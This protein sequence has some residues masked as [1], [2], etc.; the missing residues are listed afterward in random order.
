MR[1]S[2]DVSEGAIGVLT[3][4]AKQATALVGDGCVV[5]Q[6][7]GGAFVAVA[8]EHVLHGVRSEALLGPPVKLP[9]GWL[10]QA[11]SRRQT[12]R[13][14]E[15]DAESLAAAGLPHDAPIADVMVVPFPTLDAVIV[16]T[17]DRWSDPYEGSQ[18]RQVEGVVADAEARIREHEPAGDGAAAF[19]PAAAGLLDLTAA[20]LWVVDEQGATIWTNETVSELVGTPAEDII[21]QPIAE[22][23]GRVSQRRRGGF[24]G[25]EIIERPLMR[26]DGSVTWLLASSAPLPPG[27]GAVGKLYTLT[28]F[29]NLHRREVGLRLR[30]ARTEALLELAEAAGGD[31]PLEELLLDAVGLVAEQLDVEMAGIGAFDVDRLEGRAL[32]LHGWPEPD[33]PGGPGVVEMVENSATVVALRTR[34]SVLVWDFE[35]QSIY[36][37]DP[38]LTELGVRSAAVV[39]FA[40]GTAAL[41]AHSQRAGAIDGDGLQLLESVARVLAPRWRVAHQT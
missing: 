10:G 16:A 23:L 32:A 41:A 9:G 17:R 28:P 22:F 20:G 7:E 34:E 8:S 38:V 5:R 30:L 40:G 2:A 1:T 29:D 35:T 26:A 18:R 15:V 36:E 21:G 24:H 27:C 12:V 3:D 39:P 33:G 13:V 19:E 25:S 11:L 37:P 6:I 4:A 31:E 14:P